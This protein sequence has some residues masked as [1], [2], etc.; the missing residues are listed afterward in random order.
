MSDPTNNVQGEEP[1]NT[2]ALNNDTAAPTTSEDVTMTE[3]A[4]KVEDTVSADSEAK[5]EEAVKTGED[6]KTEAV[7]ATEQSN[8]S[9]N[10]N[11]QS[12]RKPGKYQNQKKFDPLLAPIDPNNMATQIRTQ[13][14]FYFG[15]SNLPLD[16]FL[17]T[18]TGGEK[19][20]P[21]PLKTICT[22]GRMRNFT[23]YEAVVAALK[24]SKTLVVSGEEGEE[25][26]SRR[27][28]YDPATSQKDLEA[29]SIYVKGFGEE[30]PSTQFDIE[31]FFA[32]FD[33][34]ESVRLRRNPKGHFKG[35]VFVEFQNPKQVEDFLALDPKPEWQGQALEIRSKK[36]YV[37]EK[38]KLINEGKITPSA[39]R[40][41]FWGPY[42]SQNGRDGHGGRGRG[43]FRGGRG[44]RGDR[45][46]GRGRGGGGG[47]RGRGRRNDDDSDDWRA[48]KFGDSNRGGR[49]DRNE[50]SS[51]NKDESSKNETSAGTDSSAK[52]ARDDDAA[53]DGQPAAKKA[54]TKA[55]ADVKTEAAPAKAEE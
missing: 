28:A 44:G 23:P 14:E 47:G 32:R 31:A 5:P 2:P 12:F 18:K 15:D 1:T 19:N 45:G 20:I 49:R 42:D 6:V 33:V 34:V 26:I 46:R 24:E 53:V 7:K 48:R 4:P 29:R 40:G 41:A 10:K 9:S 36:E 11:Q 37:E 8:N 39:E 17:W 52:R 25:L 21:V 30:K 43:N 27:E 51:A 35:S 50:E 55:D 16:N 38:T 3:N 13:V 22:F 54:D